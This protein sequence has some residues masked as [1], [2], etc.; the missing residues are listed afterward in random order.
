MAIDVTKLV[1]N[2]VF[3][4]YASTDE[5]NS[6]IRWLVKYVGPT[7]EQ[8]DMAVVPTGTEHRI[9]H[10]GVGWVVDFQNINMVNPSKR[11]NH[12]VGICA[13]LGPWQ[14]TITISQYRLHIADDTL[15]VQF[16]LRWM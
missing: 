8:P 14:P 13:P 4:H 6:I 16:K 10:C 1:L 2:D 7:I 12:N 5:T 11:E 15:A 9:Y 3:Q